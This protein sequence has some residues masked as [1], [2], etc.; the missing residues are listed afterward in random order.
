[1]YDL[2]AFFDQRF[3]MK[4]QRMISCLFRLALYFPLFLFKSDLS[5]FA[6][7]HSE[8]NPVHHRFRFHALPNQRIG[9]SPFPSFP[10]RYCFASFYTAIDFLRHFKPKKRH[11]Q[12]A[13]TFRLPRP[14]VRP[15]PAGIHAS[16]WTSATQSIFNDLLTRSSLDPPSPRGSTAPSTPRSTVSRAFRQPAASAASFWWSEALERRFQ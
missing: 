7:E 14:A 13:S 6:I 10:S 9:V 1:M 11:L 8:P 4:S 2:G 3:C 15:A 16:G 12:N 5:A